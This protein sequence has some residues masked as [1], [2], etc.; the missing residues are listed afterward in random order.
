M[1]AIRFNP[2]GTART[3][4]LSDATRKLAAD[5]LTGGYQSRLAECG[6]DIAELNLPDDYPPILCHGE[7]ARLTALKSRLEIRPEERLAGSTSNIEACWHRIP[8]TSNSSISH[9]TVDFENTVRLGLSGLEKEIQE[10]M[11]SAGGDKKDFY[12]ALLMVIDAMRIWNNR[13]LDGYREL[14]NKPEGKAHEKNIREIIKNLNNVP[15]NPPSSF[16]EALQSF[17]SFFEFQRLCGNWSGLGRFDLIL[18]DYL[19]KDLS[20]GK[21]T[22][23]EARELI[24]HFWIKGTEWCYGL[25]KNTTVD[26]GSGDAQNYQNIILGGVDQDGVPV[27][28]E[29][30]YLVLDVV[31]ELHISDYPVTVRL[32]SKTSDRLLRRIAEV[33]LLGGGI[34]SVYNEDIVL[35]GLRKLDYPE[36]EALAFTNDGCWEVI[37]PGKTHFS[38]MAQDV[39]VP[40]Q[41]ALF[42]QETPASFEELYQ[43]FLARFTAL[44]EN[45]RTQIVE[46]E[47]G[48]CG[49]PDA[50]LSLLMPSCRQ[51]GRSY[52][53][54]GAK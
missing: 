38:Y 47:Y 36:E 37:I 3:Q 5:Y 20:C 2:C 26:P 48:G 13:Y 18:G 39:L 43:N 4:R 30:T 11:A 45:V 32:N 19:E 23:D 46:R 50:V 28:N 42:A 17:W 53:C 49:M 35:A 6:F 16:A 52:S 24:A 54:F 7:N 25:R 8:G 1:A 12:K 10:Y 34:V 51:K 29:V 22:L 31:E 33:Q 41:E 9:T 27:E 40:F 15:E 44:I 14:L 21:I